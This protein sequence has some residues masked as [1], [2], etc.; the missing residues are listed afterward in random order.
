MIAQTNGVAP[1]LLHHFQ[2]NTRQTLLFDPAVWDPVLQLCFDFDFVLDAILCIAAR[3]LAFLQP[4]G[5]DSKHS[6]STSYSTLATYHLCRALSNFRT[7]LSNNLIAMHP[8]AFIAIS[9]LLQFDVWA[10]TDYL[11]NT[12]Q[13]QQQNTNACCGASFEPSQDRIF[14]FC[15]SLKGMFLKSFPQEAV[16]KS[17]LMPYIQHNAMNTLAQQV[18]LDQATLEGYR[19]FFSRQRVM[20]LQMLKNDEEESAVS[21]KDGVV[22]SSSITKQ[23]YSPRNA[24][25]VEKEPDSSYAQIVDQLALILSFLPPEYNASD[26][27]GSSTRPIPLDLMNK[28]GRHILAFPTTCRGMFTSMIARNDPHAVL[29]L[30]HF[31]RAVNKLLDSTR[32]WWA[33]KR[34]TTLEK[35]LKA[36]LVE[37]YAV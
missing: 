3:H 12:A 19:F 24:V 32:F 9:L 27:T 23:D 21:S 35:A 28:L 31:Y 18:H 36:W 30:C 10:D 16:E 26:K 4:H 37:K 14:A 7:Q 25:L 15:A 8:D 22:A 5:N 34:A 17:V 6:S 20:A 33:Q 13:Q 1:K 2:T 29:L 11:V